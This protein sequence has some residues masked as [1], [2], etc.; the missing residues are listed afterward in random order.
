MN[1]ILFGKPV[2]WQ[3]LSRLQDKVSNS[4]KPYTI[5]VIKA[6]GDV[7]QDYYY[8][9]I[10]K[11]A[12]KVGINCTSYLVSDSTTTEEIIDIISNWNVDDNISGILIMQPLFEKIDTNKLIDTID[13]TKDIENLKKENA[14]NLPCTAKAVLEILDYYK[15]ELVNK[16][17]S[18]VGRSKIVGLPLYE[19]LAKSNC[20]VNLIH[21]KTEDIED[22]LKKSDI[23]ISCVGKP[24]FITGSQVKEGAVLIDVGINED[25]TGK[26]VGDIDSSAY[27]KASSYTPVPGGV[28]SVTTAILV[29]NTVR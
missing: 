17:I 5:G 20:N 18:I 12:S 3:I 1:K 4:N 6:K 21:S 11:C 25:E 29:S 28:G 9:A 7:D 24:K 16:N 22:K 14:A 23:I 15:I 26:L 27:E 2:T 8:E 10:R 13:E 19:Y